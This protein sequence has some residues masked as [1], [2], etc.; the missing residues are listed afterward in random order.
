M[1]DFIVLNIKEEYD[2]CFLFDF[3]DE[4]GGDGD[5]FGG[6]VDFI[7]FVGSYVIWIYYD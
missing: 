4:G 1:Y 2:N 3:D 6:K 5:Y 7:I